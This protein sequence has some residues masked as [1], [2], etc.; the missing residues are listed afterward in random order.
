[1]TEAEI[2]I[3]AEELAKL[4]GTAWY[5][6]REKGPILRV[7]HERY[8][9]RAKAAIAALDRFRALKSDGPPA[10]D[11]APQPEETDTTPVVATIKPGT[12]IV[13]R[14][15]GDRRAYPCTVE[16][17]RNGFAYL[18]PENRSGI[19]WVSVGDLAELAGSGQ[20]QIEDGDSP[21]ASA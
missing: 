1:M 7:V 21:S 19:S 2:E 20:V 9:D 16:K 8:R 17:I 3:V 5:P 18:V 14:P 6:G 11:A 10:V 4:G 13:Y 15:P 12:R